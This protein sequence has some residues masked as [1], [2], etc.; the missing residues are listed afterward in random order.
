MAV[1]RLSGSALVIL[2]RMLS[3]AAYLPQPA[4]PAAALA[5]RLHALRAHS[6]GHHGA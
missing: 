3:L 1:G 2:G 6:F 5:V 4:S